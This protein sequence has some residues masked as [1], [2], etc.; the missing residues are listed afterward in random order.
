VE[1]VNAD[2]PVQE[3]LPITPHLPI[4]QILPFSIS[5]IVKNNQNHQTCEFYSF[6]MALVLLSGFFRLINRT[7]PITIAITATPPM[8]MP[9]NAA[10]DK[11]PNGLESSAT[12]S[13]FASASPEVPDV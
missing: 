2:R 4:H 5:N 3:I 8:R 11:A 12:A 10:G 6:S 9:T 1:P 13:S 7:T